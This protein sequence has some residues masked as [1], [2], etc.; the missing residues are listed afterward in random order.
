MLVHTETVEILRDRWGVPHIYAETEP[1]ALYAQGYVM[2]QDHLSVMM[3][4]YRKAVGRMAEVFGPE[5]LAFDYQQR[6]YAHEEVARAHFA[7]LSPFYRRI[8]EAF[9]I[10]IKQ[11]MTEHPEQRQEWFVDVEPYH[12]LALARYSV[13]NFLLEQARQ[14]LGQVGPPV[15]RRG[16]NQ[17]TVAGWRTRSGQVIALYDPHLP[18]SDAWTMPEQPAY[19]E[20]LMHEYHLHGGDVQVYGAQSPGLP[21]VLVGHNQH[22]AWAFTIGAPSV[23]DVYELTLNPANPLQYWYEGQ[24]RDLQ[25]KTIELVVKTPDGVEQVEREMHSSHH[26][27]L[28][29]IDEHKAYAFASAYADSLL[30]HLEPYRGINT[31]HNLSEFLE[32]LRLRMLMPMNV[33]YGDVYGNTYYQRTGR[34]PRRP[35]GCDWTKPVP[36]D[37]AA[38]M[39]EGFHETCELVQIVN[40]PAGWMQNCN[41]APDTMTEYSPMTADRYPGYIYND[42]PG[43]SNARGRRVSALLS[44]NAHLTFTDAQALAMDTYLLDA[45]PWH[46]VLLDAFDRHGNH[47]PHLRGVEKLLRQ[48]DRYA[49]KTSAAMTI[50]YHWW[51]ALARRGRSQLET[52][53][54]SRKQADEAVYDEVLRALDEAVQYLQKT[55]GRTEVT[56]GEMYRGRRGQESWPVSGGMGGGPAGDPVLKTILATNGTEPDERGVSYLRFGPQCTTVVMLNKGDVRSYSVLPYGQS[57]DPDS[58]HYTDQGRLLFS[59]GRLKD[60]W[61][62]RTRLEAHIESRHLLTFTH[63]HEHG[64]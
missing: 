3:K 36:G 50:F 58:P 49:E 12:P 4:M 23:V 20:W 5:W 51:R 27:P 46:L 60:T 6:M 15:P 10:G 22:I 40:P 13:W 28:L 42:A 45:E 52:A 55:F 41:V 19:D 1:G 35:S 47:Y 56:W 43:R 33:M 34:V 24:W 54:T 37:T 63:A 32:A 21:Y 39:W 17:W 2:A 11:Y 44:A 53:L 64:H 59:E 18:Y 62:D 25:R 38:T 14:K 16:S 7:S 29:Q 61:F 9:V 31:A 8:S 57:D 48:W 26:G 30:E